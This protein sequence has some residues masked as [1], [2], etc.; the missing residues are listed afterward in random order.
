MITITFVISMI[1]LYIY[2][3]AMRLYNLLLK[4]LGYTRVYDLNE[5]RDITLFYYLIRFL[6]TINITINHSLKFDI[7]YEKLG[8]CTY[9]NGRYM[10]YVCYDT[11][12]LSVIKSEKYISSKKYHTVKKIELIP[13][14]KFVILIL[15][16]I[17]ILIW[18]IMIKIIG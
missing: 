15:I 16:L 9:I 11:K 4:T 18:I 7:T 6:S 13:K 17:L 1:K 14:Q 10:R 3:F 12:L 5:E 2:I 8:V